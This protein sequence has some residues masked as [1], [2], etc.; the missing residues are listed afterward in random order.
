MVETCKGCLDNLE[1]LRLLTNTDNH[2]RLYSERWD[3]NYLTINNDVLVT[4]QLTSCC[5]S[6]SDTQTENNVIKTAL[7]ILKKN[8]TSNTVSLSCLIKHITELTL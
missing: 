8:L 7:K 3:I 4:N 6:W 1:R 5:T 2:T